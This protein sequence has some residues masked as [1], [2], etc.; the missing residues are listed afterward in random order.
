MSH[1]INDQMVLISGE[2][3]TGKSAS[4]MH[5]RNQERWIYANCEAGKRL[6]F[7]NK[8]HQVI[9]TDP[10]D[11]IQV[12]EHVKGNPDFDG[13][14]IDSIT[15][16]M[17]MFVSLYI[18]GL[19][20]GRAAW[21]AYSQFF[22]NMMLQHAA[23]SDKAILMLAHTKTE[24]N[25][26]TFSNTVR[27][28]LQGAVGK[29]NGV[30][31]YFSTVVSTKKVPIADLMAAP[32]QLLNITEEDEMLGYKHVFQTQITKTTVAER[33]RAPIGMFPRAE[34]FMDNDAQLLLD[35]LNAFYK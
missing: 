13:I 31:S 4:L 27:V 7:K 23:S 29:G 12:F 25:E 30:E 33:M 8:F 32:S 19:A 14:I 26:K 3:A 11:I 2:S 9:I 5:I 6:P 34:P 15:F 18:V 21:G 35:H 20:D 16:M 22:K 17:D 1:D 28:D 24:Y 10:Q